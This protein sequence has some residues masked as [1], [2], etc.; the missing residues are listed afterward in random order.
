MNFEIR[1][2]SLKLYL[3]ACLDVDPFQKLQV[4]SGHTVWKDLPTIG[5]MG[6]ELI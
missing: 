6:Q 4:P 2:K 3:E 5:F 1:S